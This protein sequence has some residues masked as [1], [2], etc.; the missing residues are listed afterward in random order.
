[1][2]PKITILVTSIWVISFLVAAIIR[3]LEFVIL[4]VLVMAQSKVHL[5]KK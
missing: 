4:L 2:H 5:W 1:M 3:H